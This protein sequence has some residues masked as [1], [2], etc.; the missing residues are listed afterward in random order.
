MAASRPRFRDR[1]EAGRLLAARLSHLAGRSPLVLA[2][3]R[4]G[5]PVAYEVAKALG[6]E[7]D[8]LIVRKLGAPGHPE[9]GIGAVVD[10]A[11]PQLVLN[12]PIVRQLFLTSDYVQAE[13]AR[14][15]SEIARRTALYRQGSPP[16][17]PAGRI[18]I[19]VDDGIATGG[20]VRAALRGL[21]K[22]APRHLVLAVPVA[23]RESLSE[24]Q[25]ECDETV[26]LATPEPFY[27][28]GPYYEDFT[29]TTDEEVKA[30]LQEARSFPVHRA[31][32]PE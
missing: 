23:P 22:A 6:G 8:L 28:V 32:G 30:L 24:L 19:V 18:V 3:P 12:E 26:C 14:Q 17:D 9:L 7:L 16:S 15:V 11:Y 10:G 2:L 5:V 31:G 20:T 29:Q 1:R 27:A 21:R 4:G 13:M 25:A